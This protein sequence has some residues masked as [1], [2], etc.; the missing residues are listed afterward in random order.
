MH[1][2][3]AHHKNVVHFQAA[4]FSIIIIIIIIGAVSIFIEFLVEQLT[5][6]GSQIKL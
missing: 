2:L 4:G 3:Y 6:V 1:V 5:L